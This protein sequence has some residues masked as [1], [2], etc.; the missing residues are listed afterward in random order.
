MHLAAGIWVGKQ[1]MRLKRDIKIRIK[2]LEGQ[3]I[4]KSLRYDGS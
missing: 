2:T 4:T 3:E 1:D